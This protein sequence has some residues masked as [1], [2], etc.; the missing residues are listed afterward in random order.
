MQQDGQTTAYAKKLSKMI[1]CDTVS[2]PDVSQPEKFKA[3][4]SVLKSLFPHV[5][6]TMEVK[7]FDGSLLLK[8]ASKIPD[9]KPILLMSHQDV[10]EATGTWRHSPFS[11]DIADGAVWGRGTVDT[12]GSLFCIFQAFEELIG[13]GYEPTTDLYIASSCT[14]EVSGP[15]A[16][17]IV[18][19][20]RSQNVELRFLLDEGGMIKSEPLKGAKG[21]FAMIGC[22]EKGTGNFRFVA[23]SGGG[24]ASAPGKNTPLVRLGRFMSEIEKHN[25]F[26]AKMNP[27]TIEMFR[28]LG[29]TVSGPMGFVFR[30]AKGLS[31][32]LSTVLPKANPL[33]G[34]LISTTLAFTMAKG[35]D[36]LNVLPQEAYVTGNS[37]FI[38]HQGPEETYRLLK[39][40]AA[41]YDIEVEVINASEPCPVVDFHSDSFKLVERT[42]RDIFPGVIPSP[43]AM[44]GGTDAR[45][46]APICKDAIRF[47]PLEINEQQFKSIHGLDEN[48]GIDA[49]PPAVEFYKRILTSV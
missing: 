6:S 36:G 9:G 17:A 41:K 12:K 18:D 16:P 32:L 26:T 45:F 37:R 28:R 25:P 1:Q 23:R 42:V 27:T 40:I 4:H 22:L 31:P 5:F 35:S 38:H 19:Y 11:G 13:A 8:W 44:T 34:A 21:R 46:F 49:L 20:L 30:H 2:I 10:V 39:G 48:I 43:Y 33:A 15:G 29:P 24:H 3:F 7:D 14:E 47:A